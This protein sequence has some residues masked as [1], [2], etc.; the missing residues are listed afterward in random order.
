MKLFFA[1]ILSVLTVVSAINPA[2]SFESQE[3]SRYGRWTV[4]VDIRD[5]GAL[6]CKAKT[7][8]GADTFMLTVNHLSNYQLLGVV[9]EGYVNETRTTFRIRMGDTIWTVNDSATK[10]TE[11][12]VFWKSS[13]GEV[14]GYR[15][16]K[17]M[18]KES[19]LWLDTDGLNIP[20]SL[21]GSS[22]AIQDLEHCRRMIV[23]GR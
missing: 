11:W 3:L 6:I 4:S 20:F 9:E 12:G 23:Q 15:F 19:V 10:N 5:D 1:L 22:K 13:M 8:N 21:D 2:F 7:V 16:R 18:M 17:D 14:D